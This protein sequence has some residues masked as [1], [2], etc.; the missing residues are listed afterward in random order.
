MKSFA[1]ALISASVVLGNDPVDCPYDSNPDN[2]WVN[3]CHDATEV[4]TS[5]PNEKVYYMD[6]FFPTLFANFQSRRE[7]LFEMQYSKI[8]A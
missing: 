2:C 1:L 7:L 3:G 8:L 4:T 6:C 5:L